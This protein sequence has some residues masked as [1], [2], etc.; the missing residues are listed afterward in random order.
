[1]PFLTL[2]LVLQLLLS[3]PRTS[4]LNV[5]FKAELLR[6][7][8]ANHKTKQKFGNISGIVGR[9]IWEISSLCIKLIY[10]VSYFLIVEMNGK[11]IYV[12]IS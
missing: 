9:Y 4:T 3:I 8:S 2:N 11:I 6:M 10:Y 7:P 5:R 12:L 1:M